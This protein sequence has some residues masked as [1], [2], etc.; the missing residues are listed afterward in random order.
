MESKDKLKETDIKN[1]TC[2]YSDD[3]MRVTD[4]DFN[5]ILSDKTSYKK[6]LENILVYDISYETFMG[7]KPLRIQFDKIDGFIKIY[8][9]VRY[10]VLL[11]YNEIYDK[12]KYFVSK[13]SGITNNIDRNFARIRIDSY[14]SLPIERILTF[15]NVIILIKSVIEEQKIN[16]SNIFLE[17]GLYKDKSNTEYF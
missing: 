4:G 8:V 6:K 17:K 2:Y 5:N 12:I 3:I 16:Y 10:L 11:E 7:T 15:H 13:K 14:N 9:G 1:R